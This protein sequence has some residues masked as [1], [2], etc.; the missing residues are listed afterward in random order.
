MQDVDCGTLSTISASNAQTGTTLTVSTALLC[1]TSATPGTQ[2]ELAS[3]ATPD[4][5]FR[6]MEPVKFQ[7]KTHSLLTQ[8][9]EL[10]IGR[11]KNAFS[12]QTTGFSTASELAFLF[13]VN[14]R[15]LVSQ[16]TVLPV[17]LDTT[18]KTDSAYKP[19][20]NTLLT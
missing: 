9:A 5:P 17:T 12:A 7:T 19:L 2:M 1:L 15:P 18:S 6:L 11:I 14:A 20:F 4:M 16:E 10:G 8:V 13:P 3:L